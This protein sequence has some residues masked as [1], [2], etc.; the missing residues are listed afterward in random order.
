MQNNI[1]Y[2]VQINPNNN[3][4]K[5]AI[6]IDNRSEPIV[7]KSDDYKLSVVRARIPSSMVPLFIFKNNG[8]E[9]SRTPDNNYY[10]FSIL[11]KNNN[12]LYTSYVNYIPQTPDLFMGS[13]SYY[14][15]FSFKWFLWLVNNCME[16]AYNNLI[17]EDNNIPLTTKPYFRYNTS[18]DDISLIIDENY[19]G[20]VELY[21]N[22]PLHKF[23]D[24]LECE[25]LHINKG[26]MDNRIIIYNN[27]SNYTSESSKYG[28]INTIQ[29]SDII[30]GSFTR[31][32]LGSVVNCESLSNN[33]KII[34]I[35]S[36]T[37]ARITGVAKET[38][39]FPNSI[40]KVNLLLIEQE[41][42]STFSWIT[43]RS[44]V[45]VSNLLP[46]NGELLANLTGNTN[47]NKLNI[48]TDIEVS[49]ESGKDLKKDIIYNP[50]AQYRYIT[51]KSAGDI[52]SIDIRIYWRDINNVLR[53]IQLFPL[54][55]SATMKLLFEKKY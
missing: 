4:I 37:S 35:I 10:S 7:T 38:G 41:F 27:R 24:G 54:S 47:D 23:F 30:S 14:Y 36:P 51:L 12:K 1:Y 53:P 55:S 39:Q 2:N 19:I 29:G 28:I 50:T 25:F 17:S 32:D 26:P 52:K 46:V 43:L 15:V 8:I 11:N 18:S 13:E 20:A 48:L 31:N 3:S 16:E 42:N 40:K 21:M 9:G 5:D 33:T 44:V 6:Y 34:E 49:Y 45:F 22:E